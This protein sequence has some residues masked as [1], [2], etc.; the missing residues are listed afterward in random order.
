MPFFPSLISRGVVSVGGTSP[1]SSLLGC[2]GNVYTKER[3]LPFSWDAYV[4]AC[5]GIVGIY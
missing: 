5:R 1:S 3:L 4:C 2:A